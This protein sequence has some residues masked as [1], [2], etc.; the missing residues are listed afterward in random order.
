MTSLDEIHRDLEAVTA[1]RRVWADLAGLAGD[2]EQR[3][4]FRAE[5]RA[6]VISGARI[7]ERLH[8]DAVLLAPY[9]EGRLLVE[10]AQ[11]R[12]AAA[13]DLEAYDAAERILGVADALGVIEVRDFPA[14]SRECP[15]TSGGPRPVG[16]HD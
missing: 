15:G 12:A 8:R 13:G 7:Y 2:P 11:E 3:A 10:P 4:A 16:G 1:A 5:A 9:L 6:A 14:A